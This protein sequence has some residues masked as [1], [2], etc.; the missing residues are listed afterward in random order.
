M[1]I[2]QISIFLEN[3]SG[4]LAE[5]ASCLSE[6]KIDLRAISVAEAS[7]FGIVRIIVDDVFN[8][9]TV[10]KNNDYVCSLTDVLAVEVSDKPGALA[11][12]IAAL[13]AEG[14]NV[15]YMYAIT[16]YKNGMAYMIVRVADTA[17]ASSILDKKGFRTVSQETLAK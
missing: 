17:K 8:A 3:Q 15:E 1:T 7:D 13:G 9:V 14:I 5:L 4:K 10:L 12:M 11:N 2:K 16:A 6:A